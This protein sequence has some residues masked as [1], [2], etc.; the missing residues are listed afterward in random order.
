MARLREF[1]GRFRPAGVPGAA[2]PAGVPTD[3]RAA[4][5]SE[6]EP[7]FAAL[8]GTL[9]LCA[10]LREQAEADARETVRRARERSA[11]VVADAQA[12]TAAERADALALAHDRRTA[13]NRSLLE[14]AGRE[15]EAVAAR[16]E[17]RI[18]GLV[19]QVVG[20]VRELGAAP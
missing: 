2:A 11:S 18:P 5:E 20:R 7:V 4:R 19:E 17:S 9:S 8:A 10:E 1:A 16:A 6:V 3:A 14:D 13:E 12:R 15:A